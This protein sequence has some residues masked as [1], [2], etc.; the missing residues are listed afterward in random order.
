[1]VVNVHPGLT[2]SIERLTETDLA[3][4][5]FLWASCCDGAG[6]LPYEHLDQSELAG[7][8]L[9][10]APGTGLVS[11]VAR[12]VAGPESE[13]EIIGFASGSYKL[14]GLQ[15]YITIILVKAGYRRQGLGSLLLRQLEEQLKQALDGRLRQFEVMFFNPVTLNWIVPGTDHHD[16]PNSPGVDV[17]CD[18]YVFLKNFGY[19]DIVYQNSFYLPL[20]DYT[21]PAD[22]QTRV[23]QLARQ[24]IHI[25]HYDPVRHSGLHELFDDLGNEPW[26][27]IVMANCSPGGKGDPLIIV[28]H[29]N[30]VCGFTGPISVQPSGRGYFAGIGVHSAY[31]NRGAG[32]ALFSV[33]CMELKGI[34]ARFMT[35][36]TGE[37]NPA[38][39]IYEAAGFK[40]VKTWADMR[41]EIKTDR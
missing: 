22:I 2:V 15:G 5:V 33:L 37:T 9:H 31:R 3:G 39:N 24:D 20:A 10:P 25:T 34:G 7:K 16:H 41:K 14:D 4:C 29:G 26:R 21:L 18:G 23:E 19:R 38:R 6:K 8:F 32:K 30:R 27:E 17:A 35:L 40:I 12:R 1:M 11:L 13:Q 28:E 36:F